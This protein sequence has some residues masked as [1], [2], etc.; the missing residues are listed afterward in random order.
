MVRIP[1]SLVRAE[2]PY[3]RSKARW[4]LESAARTARE[5]LYRY[6]SGGG[7]S[8]FG[9]TITQQERE[10]RQDRFLVVSAILGIA[11]LLLWAM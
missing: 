6:I 3:T 4:R 2:H 7:M 5:R 8:A 10:E 11:W 1:T 9:R